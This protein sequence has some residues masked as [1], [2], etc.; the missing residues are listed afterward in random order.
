MEFYDKETLNSSR[1]SSSE[2][3][4]ISDEKHFLA[5]HNAPGKNWRKSVIKATTRG[6]KAIL[7]V[8]TVC[9]ALN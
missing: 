8:N 1:L 4:S 2:A 7:E 9:C 3:F 6:Q 5:D